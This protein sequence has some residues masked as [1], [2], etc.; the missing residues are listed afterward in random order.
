MTNSANIVKEVRKELL[1]IFEARKIFPIKNVKEQYYS[2]DIGEVRRYFNPHL[3][4]RY[5]G[6][7]IGGKIGI[8][9]PSFE[10]FWNNKETGMN[11]IPFGM[12]L[13][14]CRSLSRFPRFNIDSIPFVEFWIDVILN[15]MFKFP[16]EM[17]VLCDQLKEGRISDFP[18]GYFFLPN[19]KSEAAVQWVL[20]GLR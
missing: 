14:N 5:D 6:V 16:N 20:S 8:I 2:P 4:P 12:L 1:R 9:I 15:E 19:Q 3:L 13:D 7:E 10:E 18:L 17:H 11:F